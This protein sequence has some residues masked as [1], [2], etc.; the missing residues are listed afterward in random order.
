MV[1]ARPTAQTIITRVRLWRWSGEVEPLGAHPSGDIGG[2][3][4]ASDAWSRRFV[5][6]TGEDAR[7]MPDRLPRPG[8]GDWTG[9]RAHGREALT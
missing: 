7:L 1:A 5:L 3:A 6:P 4:Q 2:D 9:W 8:L